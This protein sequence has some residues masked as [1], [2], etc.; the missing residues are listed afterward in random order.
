MEDRVL[1]AQLSEI[2]EKYGSFTAQNMRL[3]NGV[4]TIDS[5][6]NYDH[7][8]LHRIKQVLADLGYLR[9]GLRALDI[10]SLKGMFSIELALEGLSVVSVEGREQNIQRG[11]FC[12]RALGANS[13]E[14]RKDDVNNIRV[15]EYGEFDVVLCMGILYHI[16]ID[17]YA[18]FLR[19]VAGCCRGVLVID[20]F[21]ALHD[22]QEVLADGF[23]YPGTTWQEFAP[24]A[25]AEEQ[26]KT[27]HAS[28]GNDASFA[29]TK[30]ALLAFLARQGFSTIM[31][32]QV[33]MQ[34]GQPVDRPT[35]ICFR[36]TPRPLSVFPEFDYERD[37]D[38]AADTRG[39]PAMNMA[40][41]NLPRRTLSRRTLRALLGE[42][43]SARVRRLLSR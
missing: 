37:F 28:L 4:Y 12:A 42:K 18:D 10:A 36:G 29:M 31:E 15:S 22:D 9:P 23:T 8:K 11:I 6:V 16:A 40:P 34:P 26:E 7:F 43:W 24:G 38:M 33:P 21:I 3:A 35:L 30:E 41:W 2:V 19:H 25:S 32:V 39:T 14:F 17:R 20:S 27:S 1:A 13:I 5:R